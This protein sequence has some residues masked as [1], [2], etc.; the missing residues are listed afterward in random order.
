M[1]NPHKKSVIYQTI[2]S[3]ELSKQKQIM[4]NSIKTK[5]PLNLSLTRS[6]ISFIKS[7]TS[8]T[9]NNTSPNRTTMNQG[10]KQQMSMFKFDDDIGDINL[11]IKPDE[12]NNNLTAKDTIHISTVKTIVPSPV[13]VPKYKTFVK[14]VTPE[15][16]DLESRPKIRI[17]SS[18]LMPARSCLPVSDHV[19][20]SA[21]KIVSMPFAQQ[22]QTQFETNPTSAITKTKQII[23]PPNQINK[24]YLSSFVPIRPKTTNLNP[25]DYLKS[26]V[27]SF[28]APSKL[29]TNYLVSNPSSYSSLKTTTD[30]TNMKTKQNA[31][32]TLVASNKR[33][34]N[35]EN[36]EN[37]KSDDFIDSENKRDKMDYLEARKRKR[38][39]DLSCLK[40]K[41]FESDIE[42]DHFKNS[43]YNSEIAALRE[44]YNKNINQYNQLDDQIAYFY[45]PQLMS[46]LNENNKKVGPLILSKNKRG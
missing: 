43:K 13:G 44:K 30:S 35:F 45:K 5:A 21:P 38:K 11:K 4:A 26:V 16:N 40:F 9:C 17:S 29:L 22:R 19:N 14:I 23:I 39:Q 41:Q 28:Q 6:D 8:E 3:L 33:T 42:E 18:Y 10:S 27:S 20:I 46:A 15:K 32:I 31:I 1:N 24:T 34:N 36:I 7:P 2:E 12:N 37:N 25:S